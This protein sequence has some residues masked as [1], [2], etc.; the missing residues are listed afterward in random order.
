MVAIDV[1]L[2]PVRVG[3]HSRK[4]TEL[5]REMRLVGVAGILC[6][7]APRHRRVIGAREDRLE[8]PHAAIAFRSQSDG[9]LEQGNE[10]AMAETAG[11]NGGANTA[12]LF[13]CVQ[14]AGGSCR[15]PIMAGTKE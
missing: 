5:A 1:S 8:A 4:R 14:R 2:A 13:E 9:L 7:P 12:A 15:N 11:N 10:A 3:R 6:E